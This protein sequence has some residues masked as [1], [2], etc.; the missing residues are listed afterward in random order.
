MGILCIRACNMQTD[1]ERFEGAFLELFT[2]APIE[3][4]KSQD[5]KKTGRARAN[6][7]AA[8]TADFQG[9]TARSGYFRIAPM[10]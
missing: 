2:F 10:G 8:R 9:S 4:E 7:S 5:L 1:Q 3:S 6:K